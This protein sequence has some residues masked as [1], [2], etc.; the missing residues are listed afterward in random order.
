MKRRTFPFVPATC[1]KD[2]PFIRWSNSSRCMEHGGEDSILTDG[3]QEHAVTS[4]YVYIQSKDSLHPKP[5]ALV[6]NLIKELNICKMLSQ[7]CSLVAPL[8]AN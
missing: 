8:M 2:M 6:L 3:R 1:M 7:S 5:S 4:K